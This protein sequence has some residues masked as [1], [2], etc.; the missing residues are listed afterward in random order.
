MKAPRIPAEFFAD[1]G[2]ETFFQEAIKALDVAEEQLLREFARLHPDY[3]DEVEIA[4]VMELKDGKL[5]VRLGVPALEVEQHMMERV[6]TMGDLRRGIAIY[7]EM[8]GVDGDPPTKPIQPPIRVIKE[9]RD[10]AQIPPQCGECTFCA[11]LKYLPDAYVCRN[12]SD[13]V[14]SFLPFGPRHAPP[15]WCPLRLTTRR[16]E[17]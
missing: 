6:F 11:P 7:D 10:T 5:I 3:P 4:L 14:W 12:V 8:K 9:H 1:T 2:T 16:S 17:I 15:G 13:Y